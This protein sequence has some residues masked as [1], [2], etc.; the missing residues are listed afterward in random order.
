MT[1]SVLLASFL[2]AL[3]N[4][5]LEIVNHLVPSL[6][7][8]KYPCICPFYS[9]VLY[10]RL[11]F[12][13]LKCLSN[14]IS[15]YPDFYREWTSSF[16]RGWLLR[17]GLLI[18]REAVTTNLGLLSVRK[19]INSLLKEKVWIFFR[20]VKLLT[21]T[22]YRVLCARSNW[23][24]FIGE[25]LS[26]LIPTIFWETNKKIRLNNIWSHLTPNLNRTLSI[27]VKLGV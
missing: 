1:S 14:T 26:F 6:S 21:M 3:H 11:F 2:R 22:F 5:T 20:K 8:V 15:S 10:N 4:R 17:I 24:N 7:L 25:T 27:T 12:H 16:H 13:C 18:K 9:L 19:V 23:H